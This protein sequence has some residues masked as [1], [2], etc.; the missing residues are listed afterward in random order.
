MDDSNK[1]NK[2]F[3]I[4]GPQ[5]SNGNNVAI[6]H[7]SDRSIS[8]GELIN[9]QDGKPLSDDAILVQNRKGT[10]IFDVVGSVR[11]MK[12]F[13]SEPIVE[14]STSGPAMVTSDLY[15]NGWD[16]IFGKKSNIGL[17]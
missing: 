7:H 15:R 14:H 16:N 10:P 5:L 17:A 3:V 11:D 9:N 1:N 13:A 12:H 2:E 6:Y 4:A 8:T